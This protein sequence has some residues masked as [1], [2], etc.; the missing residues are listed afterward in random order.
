MYIMSEKLMYI[1]NKYSKNVNTNVIFCYL[2]KSIKMKNIFIIVCKLKDTCL[3]NQSLLLGL[4]YCFYLAKL[5]NS[6][7]VT[8]MF[9]MYY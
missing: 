4:D 1:S 7:T 8:Y 5:Q 2:K 3:E 6:L 9:N